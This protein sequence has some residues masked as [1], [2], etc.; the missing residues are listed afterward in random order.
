M[1]EIL[2]KTVSVELES[3]TLKK[4]VSFRLLKLNSDNPVG[5]LDRWRI[6]INGYELQSQNYVHIVSYPEKTLLGDKGAFYFRWRI[7][8]EY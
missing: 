6:M 8:N 7:V 1:N 4:S 3:A 2:Q 5:Y